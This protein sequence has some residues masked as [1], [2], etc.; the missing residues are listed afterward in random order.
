M[1]NRRVAV[2][3]DLMQNER[4]DLAELIWR[5][6]P[7][8]GEMKEACMLESIRMALFDIADGEVMAAHAISR[9]TENFPDR[10]W[11]ERLTEFIAKGI[12][13]T[14]NASGREKS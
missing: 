7:P 10:N 9:Y 6:R 5:A 3:E 11:Q 4:E 12:E 8:T 13:A 14:V 1:K 2:S